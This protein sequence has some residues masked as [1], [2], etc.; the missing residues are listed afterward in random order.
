LYLKKKP[1]PDDCS[2]DG[3]PTINTAPLGKISK[4]PFSDFH[5]RL[6]SGEGQELSKKKR[7]SSVILELLITRSIALI[8]K[9]LREAYPRTTVF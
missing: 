5:F 8:S 7:Y 3:G 4:T 1:P 9:K 2:S 6:F